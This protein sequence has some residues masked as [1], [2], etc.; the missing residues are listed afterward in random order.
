MI[1]YWANKDSIRIMRNALD[2]FAGLSGLVIN[3]EKSLVFLSGVHNELK[4]SLQDLLG[5]RLGSL[6]IRYLGVPLIST[7]L[8][9]SNCKP[10]E[11]QILS[12]IK[13]WTSASLTYVRRLQIIKSILFSIQVYSPL[14]YY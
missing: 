13:L 3:P 14:L 5:F 11:E 7:R 10:L 8:T 2:D 12:R 9:Y 6:P 4:T 1:Y